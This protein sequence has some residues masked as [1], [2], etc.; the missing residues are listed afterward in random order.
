[1]ELFSNVDLIQVLQTERKRIRSVDD[2]LMDDVKRI[3]ISDQ[4][5]GEK[6]L[7]NIQFYNKS[8]EILDEEGLDPTRVFNIEEIKNIAIKF[9]LR[10][11]DSQIYKGIIPSEALNE[12]AEVSQ[13]QGKDLRSFKILAP[14]TFYK[15]KEKSEADAILFT[16]TNLGNYYLLFKWGQ[17]TKWYR[18]IA[19]FPL[20][21]FENMF[22]CILG[23]TLMVSLSFPT[24]WITMDREADYF[25]MYRIAT[26]FHMLIFDSAIAAFVLFGFYSNFSVSQWNNPAIHE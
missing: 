12:I 19:N 20:R 3:L 11:L 13:S 14:I 25:S 7:E 22:A 10:F 5:S 21:N 15:L 8:Y 4:Y 6:I 26:F 18:N 16:V 23:F 9:R 2:D 24:S 1:M 17:K